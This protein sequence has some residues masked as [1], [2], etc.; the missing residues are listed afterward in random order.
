MGDPRK[1]ETQDPR[2]VALIRVL[3]AYELRTM[4]LQSKPHQGSF[5][6]SRGLHLIV[7]MCMGFVGGKEEDAFWLLAHVV[8]NVFGD[9]YFSRSSVF[10]GFQNVCQVVSVLARCFVSGFV[11]SLPDEH[12]VALWEELLHGSLVYPRM[13]LVM[14]LVGV[15][16]FL[17]EDFLDT[18]GAGDAVS[19]LIAKAEH[20]RQVLPVGWRPQLVVS[21]AQIVQFKRLADIPLKRCM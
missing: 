17:E 8:E 7:G 19:L 3:V 1:L 13:P 20:A 14:W 18:I 6:Y 21:H 10:L 2:E 15:L 9:G 5:A 11:G 16:Q 12:L 4:T